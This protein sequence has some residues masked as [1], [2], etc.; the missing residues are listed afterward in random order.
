MAQILGSDDIVAKRDV[1]TTDWTR[2]G[3][4]SLAY[5]LSHVKKGAPFLERVRALFELAVHEK[6]NA[7]EMRY[8]LNIDFSWHWLPIKN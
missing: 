4:D 6:R 1:K 3:S 5:A 2:K 8:I 7:R